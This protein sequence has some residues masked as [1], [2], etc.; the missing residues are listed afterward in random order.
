MQYRKASLIIQLQLSY[1][2]FLQS[3][4]FLWYCTPVQYSSGSWFFGCL[5]SW[6]RTGSWV[7]ARHRHSRGIN[8][9][10]A[11]L[12]VRAA[13]SLVLSTLGFIFTFYIYIYCFNTACSHALSFL[14]FPINRFSVSSIA[15]FTWFTRSQACS[16]HGLTVI[17][18]DCD[19]RFY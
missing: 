4:P 2:R 8:R 19:L 6:S 3:A 12:R 1:K 18:R 16:D 10:S 5:F 15:V 14:W 13:A 17:C 9:K 11:M 7:T